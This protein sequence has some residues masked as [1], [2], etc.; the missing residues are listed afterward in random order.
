MQ[1]LLDLI[2]LIFCWHIFVFVWLSFFFFSPEE[3]GLSLNSTILKIIEL[4]LWWKTYN[5]KFGIFLHR[6]KFGEI[7][8]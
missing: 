5:I 7:G 4:R 3:V 8:T 1:S 2:S 6:K